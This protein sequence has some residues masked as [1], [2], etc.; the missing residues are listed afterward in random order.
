MY[1]L[2]SS[3]VII[4]KKFLN[5]VCVKFNYAPNDVNIILYLLL[6]IGAILDSARF[7]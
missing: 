7:F 2:H 4:N 1:F 5:K 6:V 3:K